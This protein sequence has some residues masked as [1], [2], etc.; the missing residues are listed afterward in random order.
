MIKLPSDV[1]E[2]VEKK[3]R[4]KIILFL[5]LEAAFLAVI[6]IAGE[7]LFGAFREY[8]EILFYSTCEHML[9]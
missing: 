1:R 3:K 5:L 4:K 2:L 9:I 8:S 7:L 6:A